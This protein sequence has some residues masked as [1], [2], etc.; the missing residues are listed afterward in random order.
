[1]SELIHALN[2]EGFRLVGS[3]ESV[4]HFKML[5]GQK[6]KMTKALPTEAGLY[7]MCIER[8]ISGAKFVYVL[9][10]PDAPL[11]EGIDSSIGRFHGVDACDGSDLYW[12]KVDESMFEFEEGL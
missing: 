5:C 3:K 8:C 1:M 6:I 2:D 12:A 11:P 4:E 9:D 7:L 10:Y